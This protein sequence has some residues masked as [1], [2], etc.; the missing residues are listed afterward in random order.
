VEFRKMFGSPVYFVKGNM[1]RRMK[2]YVLL[3][4]PVYDNTEEM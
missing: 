3:P 1:Y 4:E 2:E